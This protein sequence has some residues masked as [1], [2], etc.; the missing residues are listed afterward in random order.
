M[1]DP[2]PDV[3][4]ADILHRDGPK[5]ECERW[6]VAVLEILPVCLRKTAVRVRIVKDVKG[7]K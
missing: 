5:D 6:F 1:N 3:P 4:L 2:M 7:K